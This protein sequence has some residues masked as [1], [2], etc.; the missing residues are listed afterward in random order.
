VEEEKVQEVLENNSIKFWFIRGE[1][2]SLGNYFCI[3]NSK[4]VP[5]QG[6]KIYVPML[7]FDAT[8]RKY[9]KFGDIFDFI[10]IETKKNF[11]R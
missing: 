10:V 8:K 1:V 5:I 9:V 11:Y 2:V 3:A 6:Q 7:L 4:T